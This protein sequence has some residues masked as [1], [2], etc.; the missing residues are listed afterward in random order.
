MEL[1]A[2]LKFTFLEIWDAWGRTLM[3]GMW[4][5]EWRLRYS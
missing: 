5:W 4:V 2:S 1:Y 3:V